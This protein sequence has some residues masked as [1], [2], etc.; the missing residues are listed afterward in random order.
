MSCLR[1]AFV[2][3]GA[4]SKF[5][6]TG[7]KEGSGR[8]QITAAVDSVLL[9]LLLL[10]LLTAALG[11]VAAGAGAAAGA[12]P[13]RGAGHPSMAPWALRPPSTATV[14]PPPHP[15][16]APADGPTWARATA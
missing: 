13:A 8:I 1:I 16:P 2:G 4:I 11:L 7:V 12:A 6:H 3:C 5:H 15:T 10:V 9:L 14:A